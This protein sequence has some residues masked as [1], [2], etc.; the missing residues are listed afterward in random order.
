MT[1]KMMENVTGLSELQLFSLIPLLLFTQ[2]SSH[3][4]IYRDTLTI[5]EVTL[6]A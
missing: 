2:P 4:V 5:L 3:A 1:L 6:T